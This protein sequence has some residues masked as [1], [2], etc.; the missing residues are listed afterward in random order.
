MSR[1]SKLCVGGLLLLAGNLAASPPPDALKLTPRARTLI[2][3]GTYA[4]A[5]FEVTRDPAKMA[6][7]VCDMWDSHHSLN[8]VK[9]VE[10]IAP[11]MNKVLEKARSMGMLIIHAP[12]SCMEPYK[13]HPA[14]KRAQDAPKAAKLPVD[15]AKWCYSIPEEE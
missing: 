10:E 13:D 9:R 2:K 11:R 5:T 8:A 15:I 12:S 6:V 14:R 7:I 1:A 4:V 3:D